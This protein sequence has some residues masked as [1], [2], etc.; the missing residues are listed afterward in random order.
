VP[1][2]SVPNYILIPEEAVTNN[3][4]SVDN[5]NIAYVE[6]KNTSGTVGAAGTIENH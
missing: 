6:R 5:R 1:S 3:E 4:L 2:I